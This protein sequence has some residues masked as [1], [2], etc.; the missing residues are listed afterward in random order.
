MREVNGS[1]KSTASEKEIASTASDD[2]LFAHSSSLERED[3]RSLLEEDEGHNQSD[4]LTAELKKE[5]NALE[6]DKRADALGEEFL[7][8]G[9]DTTKQGVI[10]YINTTNDIERDSGIELPLNKE[11]RRELLLSEITALNENLPKTQPNFTE[12]LQT[13]EKQSEEIKKA[14]TDIEELKTEILK[15]R[16][17]YTENLEKIIQDLKSDIE[18]FGM[19]QI[20]EVP[21]DDS[22][23]FNPISDI[24]KIKNYL[25]AKRLFAKEELYLKSDPEV[26]GMDEIYKGPKDDFIEYNPNS[27]ISSAISEIKNYLEAKRSFAK[28]AL[29]RISDLKLT[30]VRAR[31]KS[32]L[33]TKHSELSE[34]TR[35]RIIARLSSIKLSE[36][37]L[38][39]VRKKLEIEQSQIKKE[40][41]EEKLKISSEIS[42]DYRDFSA[43]K[44]S[45]LLT[46]DPLYSDLLADFD[47]IEAKRL[48]ISEQQFQKDIN[49]LEFE[50]RIV[51]IEK[52]IAK[53]KEFI[54]I[55]REF[56]EIQVS[57]FNTKTSNLA[58]G[59]ISQALSEI[60]SNLVNAE[61][62]GFEVV[63]TKI[64]DESEHERSQQ[65]AQE[66]M[67]LS[68]EFEINKDN[69]AKENYVEES[70]SL[71]F[72]SDQERE[73]KSL[74]T[75]IHDAVL[76]FKAANNLHEGRVLLLAQLGI[77]K[78]L[79]FQKFETDVE[80]SI[81]QIRDEIHHL[82]NEA[83]SIESQISNIITSKSS[84]NGLSLKKFSDPKIIAETIASK[85]SALAKS[86]AFE[87][88]EEK[89][90]EFKIAAARSISNFD[91]NEQ[92]KSYLT[93]KQIIT[94]EKQIKSYQ[95]EVISLFEQQYQFKLSTARIELVNQDDIISNLLEDLTLANKSSTEIEFL[96][97]KALAI[98]PTNQALQEQD[99]SSYFKNLLSLPDLSNP[100]FIFFLILDF[101]ALRLGCF[102]V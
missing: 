8:G 30:D 48:K 69:G 20:Y 59:E 22:I 46:S 21:E 4:D 33:L 28:E 44:L 82:K 77:E 63:L 102:V 87:S 45:S 10:D 29:S 36:E 14:H 47:K 94:Y 78:F 74:K 34:A 89:L 43:Q 101:A 53:A 90:Q 41:E 99:L 96:L 64:A 98:N 35:E 100:P 85:L 37:Q 71:F 2:D 15:A 39:N 17:P 51:E 7:E 40:I 50:V 66:K 55:Y 31:I 62:E 95:D 32:E 92:Q 23:K 9:F 91:L 76:N 93:K 97:S 54:E 19:E 24:S 25:E 73:L 86:K 42:N 38:E 26:F 16:I 72:S 49:D 65:H 68:A 5:V 75:N 79:A 6:L 84:H 12:L 88:E 80:Q 1:T 70:D 3:F 57:E 61:L 52:N 56:K 11:K 58:S 27:D 60:K 83:E 13:I 67:L 18:V 81:T